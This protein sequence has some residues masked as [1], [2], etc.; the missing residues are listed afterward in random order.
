MNQSPTR[1]LLAI[2]VGNT[3]IKFG[4]FDRPSPSDGRLPPCLYSNVVSHDAAIPWIDIKHSAQTLCADE[5]TSVVAGTKPA[6]IDKVLDSWPKDQWPL[7]NVIRNPNSFPLQ[8]ILE[9]PDKVGIDRLLNAVAANV[10]RRKHLPA[11]IV[12]CGTATTIDCVSADGAFAGGAILPGFEL[13]ARSLHQYTALLPLIPI[14]ELAEDG[15][16]V[17]P[18]GRNTRAAMRSGL[19]WGQ[20]GAIKELIERFQADID[21][22]HSDASG[23]KSAQLFLTGGGAGL[24]VPHFPQACH[25]PHLALQ[26]L[27]LVAERC[28]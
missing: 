15:K 8:V 16:S 5:L 4:L 2:D 13:C 22:L 17:M 11:F 23:Q 19:F 12:D 28:G 3:R 25:E 18:L 7:P 27:A 21:S 10:V 26:G 9:E 20:L 6:G 14:E 24:L 1:Y